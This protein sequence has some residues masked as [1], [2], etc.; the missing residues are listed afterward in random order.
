[1]HKHSIILRRIHWEYINVLLMLLVSGTIIFNVKIT[2]ILLLLSTTLYYIKY[3]QNRL[4]QNNSS[5][6]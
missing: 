4:L 3:Q 6:L 1:M 2:F 5:T